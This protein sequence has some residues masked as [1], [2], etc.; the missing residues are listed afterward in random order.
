[1]W[2]HD[3]RDI[4][5]LREGAWRPVPLRQFVL[6]IHQ[7]CNL[8]CDYC[9]VYTMADQTWRGRPALMTA[10]VWTAAVDRIAEHAERHGLDEVTVILH[11]GEPLL[12]AGNLSRIA[13]AV[14][15]RLPA[16]ASIRLAMQTNGVLLREKVLRTLRERGVRVG[17]SMDGARAD[18]DRHRPLR[19][20]RG[21]HTAVRDAL[22]LLGRPEYRP[23][24]SGIVATIDPDTDP[25]AC[26]EALLEYSPPAMSFLLPHANWSQPHQCGGRPDGAF[27]VWLVR[28]FD[29]WYGAPCQET[30]IPFFEDII[31][32]VLGGASQSEGIGLS[33]AVAVVV[34]TDGA[35]EQTDALKSAYEGAAATG[36]SVFTDT[37]DAALRH[38]GMIARQIGA[39]ALCHTCLECPIHRI[40]GAGH[41]A[42]RYR[43]GAGFLNP[44]VYCA[45]LQHLIK[46]VQARVVADLRAMRPGQRGQP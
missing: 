9:Y 42:H 25:V 14:H 30:R 7:R 43:A 11:G 24:F 19:N 5:A 21:S 15:S 2:P 36:L 1:M 8:A 40:C 28:L 12:A 4:A 16:P 13:D 46:H 23:M 27:G 37:F 45:D 22:M 31:D 44:S 3:A 38:P 29:R 18:H 33:P 32:M 17:V 35:I 10:A 20:G 6:K 26:Y 39:A 34:D 41:Y